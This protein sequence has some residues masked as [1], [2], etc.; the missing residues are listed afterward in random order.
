MKDKALKP[1]LMHT[2]DLKVLIVGFGKV[3]K[4]KASAYAKA[5][6]NVTVVDPSLTSDITDEHLT[7]HA[8]SFE[9]FITQYR[10]L[11][12]K[13]HLIVI[14]TASNTINQQVQEH[15]KMYAKLYN[16]ADSANESQFS[17]MMYDQGPYHLV[18]VSGNAASPYVSKYLLTIIKETLATF[19]IKKR[20]KLLYKQSADLKRH[21]IAYEKISDLEDETLEKLTFLKDEQ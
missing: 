16:R 4:R 5:G 1:I 10:D 15:C 13:Q 12:L 11:F 19:S 6:A 14:C 18:A 8:L 9:A 2:A 17:D 7:G 21:H 3:G 20:I